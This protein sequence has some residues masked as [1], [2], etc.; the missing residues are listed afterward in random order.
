MN[1]NN[2]GFTLIEVL[3][4]VAIIGVLAAIAIP[5]YQAYVVRAQIAEGLNLTGVFKQAIAEYHND[6]G[7]YPADNAEAGLRDPATYVGNY[8]A[9][10]SIDG[11]QVA[12]LFGNDA[13]AVLHGEAVLLVARAENGS[14]RWRC[15]GGGRISEKFLPQACR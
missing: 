4:V 8:V 10:I 11:A 15:S 2:D 3:I 1:K 7:G 14:V 12:I 13:H 9:S 6:T 5:A